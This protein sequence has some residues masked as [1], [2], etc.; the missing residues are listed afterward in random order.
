MT[1]L[2]ILRQ[3]IRGCT[4][5]GSFRKNNKNKNKKSKEGE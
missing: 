3:Y 4:Y 1:M 5:R 2:I